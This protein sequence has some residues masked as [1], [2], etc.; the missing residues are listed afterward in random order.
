MDLYHFKCKVGEDGLVDLRVPVNSDDPE[1]EIVVLV[2]P[3]SSVPVLEPSEPDAE[4]KAKS[5]PPQAGQPWTL[6]E[7]QA[8]QSMYEAGETKYSI[9]RQMGR[10]PLA[11]EMRLQKLAMQKR[12]KLRP[13]DLP[14]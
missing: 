14:K 1:V 9:A 13:E 4:P 10:S 2:G 8:L 6:E 7:E 3:V 11:I 12:I 5:K